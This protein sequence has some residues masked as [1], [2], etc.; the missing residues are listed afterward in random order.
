[1]LSREIQSV[2]E[3]VTYLTCTTRN[4]NF[5]PEAELD[6]SHLKSSKILA[7]NKWRCYRKD[8]KTTAY[9]SVATTKQ[10]SEFTKMQIPNL[11]KGIGERKKLV[12][13]GKKNPTS[14][15]THFSLWIYSLNSTNLSFCVEVPGLARKDWKRSAENQ[16]DLT[17][18]IK[19][20]ECFLLGSVIMRRSSLKRPCLL[21]AHN[22][23]NIISFERNGLNVPRQW[24]DKL[25]Q[26]V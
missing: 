12:A 13:F 5:T 18:I 9:S 26:L 4:Q 2:E 25:K 17:T 6:K 11:W 1:M 22:V 16:N 23:V 21:T 24:E 8:H 15:C 19:S 3:N 14:K 7:W 10:Q 20:G